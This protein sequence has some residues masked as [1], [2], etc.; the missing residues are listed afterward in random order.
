MGLDSFRSGECGLLTEIMPDW[1]G[2]CIQQRPWPTN[3]AELLRHAE[4]AA[5]RRDDACT[6]QRHF[7]PSWRNG[8][9]TANLV[10]LIIKHLKWSLEMFNKPDVLVTALFGIWITSKD[11]QSRQRVLHVC[12]Q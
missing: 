10:H 7:L 8:S 5:L 2:P 6:T 3:L 4:R 12:L 9:Q 11:L 1:H